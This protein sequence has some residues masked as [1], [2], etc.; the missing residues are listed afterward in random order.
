MSCI[1]LWSMNHESSFMGDLAPQKI[2][3]C[4]KVKTRVSI[5]LLRFSLEAHKSIGLDDYN[6]V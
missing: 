5:N 3:I 1:E 4:E 2:A 6:N